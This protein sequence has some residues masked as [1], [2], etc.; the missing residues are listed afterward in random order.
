ML[1]AVAIFLAER[2]RFTRI[3]LT[4][5]VTGFMKTVLIL[6][7]KLK[8]PQAIKKNQKMEKSKKKKVIEWKKKGLAFL[9][10]VISPHLW[11]LKQK[12]E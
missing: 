2:Q 3:H 1:A 7:N 5:S 4:V 9:L 11:R 8:S 6:C 10:Y 12:R